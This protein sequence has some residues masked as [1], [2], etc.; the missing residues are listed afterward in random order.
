MA[1]YGD[2]VAGLPRM[3]QVLYYHPRGMRFADLATEV[4]QPEADVRETLR[5]YYLTDLAHY[6]PDLVARP[7]VLEFFG[8]DG[9][10]ERH[11]EPLTAPMVRLVANDPGTELGIAYTSASELARL[12]RLAY[13]ASMLHPENEVLASAVHKLH[14]GLLP[15]LRIVRPE[16]WDRLSDVQAAITNSRRLRLVYARQRE[17]V[18]EDL[19]VEP[20]WLIR[21][22]R[23][24]E[25]DA[26]VDDA[27]DADVG[28]ADLGVEGIRTFI[29][30]NVR[31]LDVLDETFVPPD[32][33]AEMIKHYRAVTVVVLD[34]PH[35]ARWAVDKYAE[36]VDLI[37][38]RVDAA[39]LR[40]HLLRPVR[41]R[42]GLML[43]VGG[44][45]ARVVEPAE[46][47]D[48]GRKPARRMLSC[49]E[50]EDWAGATRVDADDLL[51]VD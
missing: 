4:G 36:R 26:A 42:V 17:P 7:E 37:E 8:G 13:D 48:A 1:I 22:H 35:D 3:L 51:E 30:S 38:D 5:A 16:P 49:Y 2:R 25:L 27:T 31:E 21:T 6:L 43:V 15:S 10:Q 46:L 28:G 40:V 32:G 29:V 47:T 24:W 11:G 12:Y 45:S 50:T 14:A 34:V 41:L 44:P 23:G 18:I 33:L 39:R 19:V 9:D 20:Y